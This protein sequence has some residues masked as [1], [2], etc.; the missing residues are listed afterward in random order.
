VEKARNPASGSCVQGELDWV[1]STFQ[2]VCDKL[3][4]ASMPAKMRRMARTRQ[5]RVNHEYQ[6][7]TRVVERL[8]QAHG[9]RQEERRPPAW[10]SHRDGQKYRD[11]FNIEHV[12]EQRLE[13]KDSAS[14]WRGGPP[15]R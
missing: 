14:Q 11:E 1:M 6:R 12:P 2:R 5:E 10:S 8:L 7:A 13:Y 4:L 15:C 9:G 3:D